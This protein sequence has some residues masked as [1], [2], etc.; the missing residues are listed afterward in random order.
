MDKP[1]ETGFENSLKYF[2]TMEYYEDS[3]TVLDV[4]KGNIKQ[5][6]YFTISMFILR[7]GGVHSKTFYYI[8]KKRLNRYIGDFLI[9]LT[10]MMSI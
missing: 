5:K 3:V 4:D 7:C 1:E 10:L 8:N 2:K 9:Y 6:I